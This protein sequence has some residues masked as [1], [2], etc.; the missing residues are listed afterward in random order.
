MSAMG[1]GVAAGVAQTAHQAQQVARRKDKRLREDQRPSQRV[2]DIYETHLKVL[3]EHDESDS[4][5]RLTVDDQ[6]Q[7]PAAAP[8]L[9]EEP[10]EP[11]AR[12][13]LDVK[14]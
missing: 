5:P 1:T 4:A 13:H 2:R 12:P 14:A 9:P 7:D 8:P 11:G 3:D 6:M 10:D